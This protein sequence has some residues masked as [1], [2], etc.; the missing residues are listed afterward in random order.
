MKFF[1]SRLF[2]F[3]MAIVLACSGLML[4][5]A[6]SD[7]PTVFARAL[8]AVVTPV[9]NTLSGAVDSVKDFFGYFYRYAALEEEILCELNKLGV[10]AQGFGGDVTALGVNIEYFPTHIAGLPVAVTIS[11]HVTRHAE[12]TI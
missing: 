5:S 8:G 1:R 12:I 10:G 3:L 7:Q 2:G 6:S 11:C 4:W 9:Q